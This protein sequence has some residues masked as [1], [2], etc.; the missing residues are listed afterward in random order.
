MYK[1][2]TP[3]RIALGRA[4]ESL[5]LRE[6]LSFAAAHAMARDAVHIPMDASA[7]CAELHQ[8]GFEVLQVASRAPH[9][10]AY[11]RR[12]DWGR[13]LDASAAASLAARRAQDAE[14]GHPPADLTVVIADGLS[15][16][17]AQRNAAATV[18]ALRSAL[19]TGLRIGPLVLATQARVALGDEVG[20]LLASRIL[21]ILIGERPGLSSPDSLGAYL[22]YA[23]SLIHI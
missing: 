1:R 2:Q 9:R 11:L 3:A 16:V 6:V 13:R 8:D 4:G 7:L 17:A 15:A 12:P 5:P 19:P 14:A 10:D 20:E 22:T 23:L 18:R 21:L